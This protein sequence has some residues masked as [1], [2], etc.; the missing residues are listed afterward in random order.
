MQAST[1]AYQTIIAGAQMTVAFQVTWALPG[2]IYPDITLSAEQ[3]TVDRQLTT[4]MPDGTRLI[5]GYPAASV[6]CTLSGLV[7]ATPGASRSIAWLL[8]PAQADSPL[9][10]S[11]ALGAQFTVKAGVYVPGTLNPEMFTIFVGSVDD[12]TV[13]MKAGTVQL[14]ALDYR[15]KFTTFPTLPFGAFSDDTTA[16]N[17][18]AGSLGPLLTS[19]WV[20]NALGE[21]QGWYTSPPPR[22]QVWLRQT[23]HGA[24][25]PESGPGAALQ[26]VA[27]NLLDGSSQP[28]VPADNGWTAGKFGTQVPNTTYASWVNAPTIGLPNG[29]I[30]GNM[31]SSGDSWFLE[32]WI[33]PITSAGVV[34]PNG[35]GI[36]L[37]LKSGDASL[38]TY[39][40]A[41][42][43]ASG[44]A[45]RPFADVHTGVE[46]TTIHPASLT[47]PN[48]GAWHYFSI[49]FHY[50]SATA[51]TC[52]WTVDGSSQ[53]ANGSRSNSVAG[54]VPIG[55]AVLSGYC[56]IES[57]QVTNESG[58]PPSNIGFV[59]STAIVLDPSLNQLTTIPD[60]TGQDAWGVI[61]AIAQAEGA[62][63]GFDE[64]GIFR[65]T[66]RQTL[67]GLTSS[68]TITPKYS[69]KSLDVE[70]GLSF[71]RN[72]IQV[73]VNVQQVSAPMV[74]W[75][76]STLVGI[77]GGGTRKIFASFSGPVVNM[78]NQA[79][80]M[81]S[82][83][84]T[85]GLSY[86]RASTT[87]A[88]GGQEVNNLSVTITQLSPTT[89]QITIVNPN[90]Y[91]VYLV[92]YVG[93]PSP[94]GTPILVI[95]GQTTGAAASASDGT[96]TAGTSNMADSQWPPITDDPFQPGGAVLNPRGEKL[97][98]VSANS[99]MQ[100]LAS[101]QSF[102]DDLLIDLNRPKPLWRNVAVVPDLSIQLADRLT[103][104][105]PD[106]T[107]V[108]DP[109]F[110][111]GTHFTATK[112]DWSQT[113]DMRAV[114]VPGGW[115]LGIPGR[116]EMGVTTYV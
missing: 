71:V 31:G 52:T 15:S 75:S 22:S 109:A 56:P 67:R 73:P 98:T 35:W 11:D 107:G 104:N 65:F 93:Y 24:N 63:A 58:T 97:L 40:G 108:N 29:T 94:P 6:T 80:F 8:N 43:T 18:F 85:P 59:P 106:V 5:T 81:P 16:N 50:T 110:V 14:T 42:A 25:W 27:P 92:S 76:L 78:D 4:D 87:P 57:I 49:A 32:C 79:V 33:K 48:D 70:M 61:Q 21:S 20:L 30:R 116:S 103:V 47:I 62:I 101:G 1:A 82:G 55:V 86:Y 54:S 12:Y 34:E 41:A 10:R 96:A 44:N 39:I 53:S 72:H 114:G 74:V 19:H 100:D 113:L 2:G 88:G 102:A 9:Y 38:N 83:G 37:Q 77:G 105:D 26:V 28:V 51:F 13:S 60:V 89:A 99:W 3:L 84:G 95:G 112:T 91:P 68:R 46:D 17:T 90:G 64:T 111:I 69:L 7:D 36:R 115:L 66:N 45:L 23:N